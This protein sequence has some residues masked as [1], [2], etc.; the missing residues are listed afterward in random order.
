M[1]LDEIPGCRGGEVGSSS[2]MCGRSEHW[3]SDGSAGVVFMFLFSEYFFGR[4]LE[5]RSVDIGISI[6]I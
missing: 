2:S 6:R 3:R 4:R 1:R 5:V